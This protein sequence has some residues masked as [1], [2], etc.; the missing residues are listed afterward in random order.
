MWLMRGSKS[1][2][3]D[4]AEGAV[5]VDTARIDAEWGGCLCLITLVDV[6][7]VERLLLMSRN[8]ASSPVFWGRGPWM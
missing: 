1:W 5:S 2:T 6:W 3:T 8:Q 7:G 4:T